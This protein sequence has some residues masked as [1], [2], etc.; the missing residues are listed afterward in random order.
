MNVYAAE[1]KT[2]A[3]EEE[4]V[5]LLQEGPSCEMDSNRIEGEGVSEVGEIPATHAIN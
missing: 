1:T 2:S 5:A 4:W 3:E